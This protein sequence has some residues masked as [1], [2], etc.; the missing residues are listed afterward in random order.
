MELTKQETCWLASLVNDRIIQYMDDIPPISELS[1]AEVEGMAWYLDLLF[2]LQ[3]RLGKSGNVYREEIKAR[4]E[5][6]KIRPVQ[7]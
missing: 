7:S 6:R 2:K 3:G 4:E 5:W 1:D